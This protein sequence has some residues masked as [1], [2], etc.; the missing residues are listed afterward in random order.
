MPRGFPEQVLAER[1]RRTRE[2]G[3]LWLRA[4]AVGACAAIIVAATTA[5]IERQQ[6]IDGLARAWMELDADTADAGKEWPW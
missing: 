4:S 1:A 6:R 5:A 2:I 3:T